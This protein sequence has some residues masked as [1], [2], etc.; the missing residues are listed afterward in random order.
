MNREKYFEIEVTDY[1]KRLCRITPIANNS[2]LPNFEQNKYYEIIYARLMKL[3]YPN[4]LRFCR[5]VLGADLKEDSEGFVHALFPKND[6]TQQFVKL[7]NNRARL[8]L[9]EREHPDWREHQ[10]FINE[11]E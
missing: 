2:F 8:V 9:W 4:Y 11:K 5:D 7:L 1:S 10:K 3:S 6:T